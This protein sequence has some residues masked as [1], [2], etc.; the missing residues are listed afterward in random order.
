M[1]VS[2]GPPVLD[3][4][5]SSPSLSSLTLSRVTRGHDSGQVDV[6]VCLRVMC[7]C[8]CAPLPSPLPFGWQQ[9][10]AIRKSCLGPTHSDV[11]TSLFNFAMA[12]SQSGDREAA[13][14]AYWDSLAIKRATLGPDHPDIPITLCN[15]AAV[16]N[17]AGRPMEAVPLLE[18]AVRHHLQRW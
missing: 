16:V 4:A 18:E 11:A 14:S 2:R 15:M 9:V 5:A 13:L 3:D 1:S 10:V 8:M 6:D 17:G 7:M 12:A